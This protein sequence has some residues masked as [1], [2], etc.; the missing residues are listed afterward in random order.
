MTVSTSGPAA[1]QQNTGDQW[2]LFRGKLVY[3]LYLY[4]SGRKAGHEYSGDTGNRKQLVYG[5]PEI[6]SHQASPNLA[7]NAKRLLQTVFTYFM[8]LSYLAS[9]TYSL[10]FE[11]ES[12][13]TIKGTYGDHG[14][15]GGKL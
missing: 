5:M 2:K 1:F 3:N 10:N 12:S 6:R 11:R 13:L 7:G 15:P 14:Y 9:N 4:G 8:I